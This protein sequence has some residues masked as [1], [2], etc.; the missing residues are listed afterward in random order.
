[1]VQRDKNLDA[2]AFRDRL[3]K[4]KVTYILYKFSQVRLIPKKNYNK[5]LKTKAMFSLIQWHFKVKTLKN[6]AQKYLNQERISQLETIRIHNSFYEWR[7][8]TTEIANF[9]KEQ[10]MTYSALTF[11]INNL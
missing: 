7:Q 3:L 8:K 10:V 4:Q 2:L 1:M 5:T 6:L 9:E 11:R